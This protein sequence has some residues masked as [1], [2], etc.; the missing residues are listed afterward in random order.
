LSNG[1][2]IT[3]S[4]ATG[5]VTVGV[6]SSPS[7][8]SV[9]TSTITNASSTNLISFNSGTSN[10]TV[11]VGGASGYVT[12]QGNLWPVGNNAEELGDASFLWSKINGVAYYT[13]TGN[14]AGVTCS[15]SPTGAFATINGIVTHC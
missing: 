9:Q 6:S 10:T 1:S 13:G 15:G 12:A 14:T 3:L 11:G 7:F 4:G 2:N 8:T 5:G